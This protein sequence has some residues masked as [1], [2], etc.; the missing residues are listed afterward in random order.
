MQLDQQE[1]EGILIV[2][3]LERRIDASL[4]GEFK[5]RLGEWITGGRKQIVID[6]SAV[7]FIDSSGLGAIV[8]S[9]KQMGKGGNLVLSDLRE[10][11]LGLFRLTRMN[12]VFQIYTT[13]GEAVDALRGRVESREGN[14]SSRV[15]PAVD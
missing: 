13:S 5:N 8:G 4:A 7:E 2:R 3:P 9:L 15:D 1:T 11:I 14:G 6:L 10:A 12:R